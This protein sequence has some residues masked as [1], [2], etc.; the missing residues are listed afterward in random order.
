[1]VFFSKAL[2]HP[3]CEIVWRIKIEKRILAVVMANEGFK[4]LILNY[5]I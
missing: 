4:I 2:I 5:Y 1:M 3:F